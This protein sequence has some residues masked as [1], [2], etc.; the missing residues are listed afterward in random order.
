MRGGKER[1]M[2]CV[3]T[4]T[5]AFDV[6]RRGMCVSGCFEGVKEGYGVDED[7]KLIGYCGEW[8]S[9]VDG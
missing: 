2:A 6:E 9:P 7:E 5:R 3:V 8:L 4:I 1:R